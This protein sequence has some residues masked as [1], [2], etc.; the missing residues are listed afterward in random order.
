MRHPCVFQRQSSDLGDKHTKYRDFGERV[1]Q[2]YRL[3]VNHVAINAE[4]A[5]KASFRHGFYGALLGIC[6]GIVINLL[7]GGKNPESP[8]ILNFIWPVEQLFTNGMQLIAAPVSFLCFI[9][10]ILTLN[11]SLNRDF[12]VCSVV[13][14][15]MAT[16]L[17]ALIIGFLLPFVPTK[18]GYHYPITSL[19]FLDNEIALQV[20]L[21]E[22]IQGM[23]PS[24]L[25]QAFIDSNPLPLILLATAFGVAASRP[26]KYH[27]PIFHFFENAK[28]LICAVLDIVYFFLPIAAFCAAADIVITMGMDA[29]LPYIILLSM[30]LLALLLILLCYILTL[31]VNGIHLVPLV[32]ILRVTLKENTKIGSNQEAIPYNIRKLNEKFGIPVKYLNNI[33]TLGAKENMDANCALLGI[34]TMVVVLT[35]GIKLTLMQG[36]FLVLVVIFLSLGSPNLPG[37]MLLGML[38]IFTYLGIDASLLCTYILMEAFLTKASACVNTL[39]DLTI[40]LTDAKKSDLIRRNK[41]IFLH[42]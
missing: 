28:D 26:G 6:F 25:L 11:D 4:Y 42:K 35:S 17:F 2:S 37:S 27:R 7:A 8:F 16:S 12:N 19:Y 15:M 9:S 32:K 22:F 40:A 5:S 13:V 24:S 31:V 29:L 38:I 18:L 3:A 36:F 20:T 23:M 41:Q 33:L 14:R 39:G 30:C 21:R 1:Q 10:T 34:F